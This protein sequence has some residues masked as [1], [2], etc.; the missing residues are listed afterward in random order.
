MLHPTIRVADLEALAEE[1]GLDAATLPGL[2]EDRLLV[3]EE[4]IEA[5]LAQGGFIAE[6]L[7]GEFS[8]QELAAAIRVERALAERG[9]TPDQVDQL[10]R[11]EL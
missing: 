7:E 10:L 11:P 2:S 8:A 3:V 5:T 4:G 6:V 9:L 1:R